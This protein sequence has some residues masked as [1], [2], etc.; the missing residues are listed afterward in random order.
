LVSALT[1]RFRDLQMAVAP[2]LQLWMYGSCILFPL[3]MVSPEYQRILILNPVV[4]IVES[5]RFAVM[6]QG[7]IEIWQWLVS[8]VVTLLISFVGLI[9]FNRVEKNMADTI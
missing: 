3:S 8:L 7:Q 4:P 1:T 9:M 2:L 6:G 5:F